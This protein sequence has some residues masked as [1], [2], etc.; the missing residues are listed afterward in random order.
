MITENLKNYRKAAAGCAMLLLCLWF[1][2]AAAQE[3]VAA[4]GGDASGSGGSVAYTAGQVAYTSGATAEVSVSQ[5][6][7]QPYEIFVTGIRQAALDIQCSVFPNPAAG[8]LTLEVRG[9]D[10]EPLT[11]QLL[12]IHGKLLESGQVAD[13]RTQINMSGLASAPYLLHII[14]KNTTVQSFKIIKK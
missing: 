4:S 7:Q 11:W 13:I 8:D 6:V 10:Y 9:G 14:R 2:P 12:D 3:T 1:A 5:G